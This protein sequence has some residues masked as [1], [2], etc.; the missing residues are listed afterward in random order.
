MQIV[1]AEKS[2]T[3]NAYRAPQLKVYGGMSMLTTSGTGTTLENSDT[4]GM[5]VGN[6]SKMC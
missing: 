6:T 5:C 1:K 2:K 3:H 4:N